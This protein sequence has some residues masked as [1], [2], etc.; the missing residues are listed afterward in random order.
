MM[1]HRHNRE[2]MWIKFAPIFKQLP[3][4][5]GTAAR[6]ANE[7]C[8][9]ETGVFPAPGGALAAAAAWVRREGRHARPKSR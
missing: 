7:P 2:L 8:R 1:L 6:S 9:A 3:K 5:L 4:V